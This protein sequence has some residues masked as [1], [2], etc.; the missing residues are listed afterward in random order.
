MLSTDLQ[1]KLEKLKVE[2]VRYMEYNRLET[3]INKTEKLLTA[4]NYTLI[5]VIILNNFR[6]I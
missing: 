2:K 6:I 4:M 1:P 5:N 3:E